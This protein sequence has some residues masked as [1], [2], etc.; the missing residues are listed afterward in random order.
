VAIEKKD[1]FEPLLKACP[2][3]QPIYK[4]FLADW[5]EDEDVELDG[6]PYYLALGN[7]AHHLLDLLRTKNTQTFPK[8]FEVVELWQ[9]TGSHYVQEA[10]VI[11]LLEGIQ[12]IA[13][14]DKQIDPDEFIVWLGPVSKNYWDRLNRFWDGDIGSLNED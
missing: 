2:T 5:E 9:V 14:H 1:M 10:A 6:L 3:F 4:K 11:G 8:V 13:S 7:L 12:N